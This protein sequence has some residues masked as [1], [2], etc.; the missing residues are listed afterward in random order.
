MLPPDLVVERRIESRE[1]DG[2]TVLLAPRFDGKLLGRL[3]RALFGQSFVKVKLDEL[4]AHVWARCDGGTTVSE[5]A[6]SLE[7]DHDAE[8]ARERMELFLDTLHRQGWVRYLQSR[9]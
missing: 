2:R 4:G 5:I 1:E 6:R 7:S 8:K 3:F 9:A